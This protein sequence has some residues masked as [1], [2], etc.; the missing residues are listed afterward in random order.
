M[1][2]FV[3]VSFLLLF[4]SG[5]AAGIGGRLGRGCGI[6]GGMGGGLNGSLNGSLGGGI[7]DIP[8]PAPLDS[9]DQDIYNQLLGT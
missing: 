8:P 1:K 3:L 4:V 2:K 6:H 9:G 5:C 7:G